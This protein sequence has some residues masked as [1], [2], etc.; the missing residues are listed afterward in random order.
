MPRKLPKVLCK[1]KAETKWQQD[2]AQSV[3]DETER[4]T[5]VRKVSNVENPNRQSLTH[6]RKPKDTPKTTP[7]MT[8]KSQKSQLKRE[9]TT[10]LLRSK[11]A[12]L[13][14]ILLRKKSAAMV[15]KKKARSQK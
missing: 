11:M 6:H 15:M 10:V 9:R 12:S 14:T 13:R 7:N 1:P 8:K 3:A 4:N 2:D 5:T